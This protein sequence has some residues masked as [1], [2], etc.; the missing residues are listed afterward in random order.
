MRLK[1]DIGKYRIEISKPYKVQF[2][3]RYY[4]HRWYDS[5][6]DAYAKSLFLGLLHIH[7][8]DADIEDTAICAVCGSADIGEQSCGDEGWT[9]CSECGAIEQGYDYISYRDAEERGLV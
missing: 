3:L 9:M 8:F 5:N 7:W 6:T 1:L 2:G 4:K